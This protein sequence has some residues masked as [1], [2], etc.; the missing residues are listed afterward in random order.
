MKTHHGGGGGGAGGDKPTYTQGTGLLF[1]ETELKWA[2]GSVQVIID[3][4]A[5]SGND[6]PSL[7]CN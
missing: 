5:V 4:S 6:A 2:Q 3:P 7:D 1:V